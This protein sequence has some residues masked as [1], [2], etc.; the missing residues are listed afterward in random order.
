MRDSFLTQAEKGTQRSSRNYLN[1]I[2]SLEMNE[3]KQP[4]GNEDRFHFHIKSR[5]KQTPQSDQRSNKSK[6]AGIPLR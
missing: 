1:E 4:G 5:E 3:A 2:G 6:P